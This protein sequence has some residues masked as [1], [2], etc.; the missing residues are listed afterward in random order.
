M[1][2]SEADRSL[3]A[4]AEAAALAAGGWVGVSQGSALG[5]G[6]VSP[7]SSAGRVSRGLCRRTPPG[8]LGMLLAFAGAPRARME[9]GEPLGKQEWSMRRT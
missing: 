2:F 6:V 7:G 4:M 5:S 9:E 3:H 8:V 1:T